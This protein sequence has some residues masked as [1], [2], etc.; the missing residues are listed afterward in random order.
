MNRFAWPALLTGA[1]LA[2]GACTLGGKPAPRSGRSGLRVPLPEGWSA[3]PVGE[4]LEA[5]LPGHPAVVLES[6]EDA[7]PSVD[8]LA[9]AA[10]REGA[11]SVEKES[12]SGF[13]AVR[14][15][16]AHDGGAPA[17]GFLAVK[18][19][20][21]RRVWCSSA[22]GARADDLVLALGVCRDVSWEAASP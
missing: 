11:R 14:Y 18:A 4:R 7:L 19:S 17:P 5:G 10:Q 3:V 8:A 9:A 12:K 15:L 13:V 22:P 2:S 16:L 21:E 6:R 20:G 1:V